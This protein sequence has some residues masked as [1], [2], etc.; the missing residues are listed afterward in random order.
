MV[1]L[2]CSAQDMKKKALVLKFPKEKRE[3]CT[4]VSCGPFC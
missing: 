1:P 4:E 2:F 3:T